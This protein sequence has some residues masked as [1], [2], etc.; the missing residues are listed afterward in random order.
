MLRFGVALPFVGATVGGATRPSGLATLANPA[1]SLDL[2]VNMRTAYR[3]E[4]SR[5]GTLCRRR[6]SAHRVEIYRHR[7]I[8]VKPTTAGSAG[9]RIPSTSS[10][11]VSTNGCDEAHVAHHQRQGQQGP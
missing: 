3:P 9:D 8:R 10:E 6:S 4:P 2:R 11:G 5:P 7:A 1:A